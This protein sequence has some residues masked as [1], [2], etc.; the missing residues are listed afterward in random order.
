MDSPEALEKIE[1]LHNAIFDADGKQRKGVQI[2][3]L[4]AYN[5][6]VTMLG[7]QGDGDYKRAR[8]P[9][10]SKVLAAALQRD[11]NLAWD[12]RGK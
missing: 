5:E 8:M 1:T 11:P 7:S 4:Q 2:T 6:L 9:R 12:V 10:A 3:I